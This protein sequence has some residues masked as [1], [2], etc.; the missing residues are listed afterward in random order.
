[1]PNQKMEYFHVGNYANQKDC[2]EALSKASVLGTD[3]NQTVE[4]IW[5]NNNGKLD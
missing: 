5:V 4:C 2:V 3:K 1:M